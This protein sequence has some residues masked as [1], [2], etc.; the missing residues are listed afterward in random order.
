MNK[1][2]LSVKVLERYM[3][4]EELAQFMETYNANL[5]PLREPKKASEQDKEILAKYQAGGKI[6]ALAKEYNISQSMISTAVL[7]AIKG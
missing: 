5:Q 1:R 3:S 7:R 4:P 2:F 6:S